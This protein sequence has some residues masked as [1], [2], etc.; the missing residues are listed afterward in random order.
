MFY[1][2]L[3][4][5]VAAAAAEYTAQFMWVDGYGGGGA[6]AAPLQLNVLL[7][8]SRRRSSSDKD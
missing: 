1:L 8:D 2:C 3:T 4:Q 7:G 5:C 6:A